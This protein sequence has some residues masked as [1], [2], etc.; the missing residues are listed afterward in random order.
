MEKVHCFLYCNDSAWYH[1]EHGVSKHF[2]YHGTSH[3]EHALGSFS[4]NDIKLICDELNG[5]SNK[6]N[7]IAEKREISNKLADQ[8]K[9]IKDTLGIE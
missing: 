4:E 9:E 7:I 6:V 5:L 1:D 8:I 3:L 2:K